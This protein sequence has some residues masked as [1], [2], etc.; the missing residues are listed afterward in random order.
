MSQPL[1]ALVED[2]TILR[3]ELCFQLTHLGFE[4][5]G[6]ADAAQLYRRLAVRRFAVVI[7]DIGLQGEDGLNICH[8]L[9]AHDKQLGI[10]FVTARALREDRL[11]GLKA[12][13]DAYLSKPVDIDELALLLRRLSERERAAPAPQT[14][15]TPPTGAWQLN[16]HGNYLLTPGGAQVRLSINETRVLQVLLQ[17][18]GETAPFSRLA[19]A[20]GLLPEE[21]DKHRLEVII[22]RLR[23]K[24]LRET[25]SPLPLLTQRSVGYL[26]AT[27]DQTGASTG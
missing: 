4:V 14:P 12:G 10:L 21:Y 7:L 25:G 6:F 5:E 19:T 18:P 24:V 17:H 26:F 22:S 13:A 11:T 20:L 9:R 2:E 1:I 27:R 15:T 8:Y 23:D 3:E 16:S